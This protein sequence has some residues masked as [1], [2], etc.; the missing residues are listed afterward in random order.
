MSLFG[1]KKED[2]RAD[3]TAILQAEIYQAGVMELRDIIAPAALKVNPKSLSLGSK[4]ARTY[5]VISYPR[6]LTQGWFGPIINL[7][8]IFDVS[9]F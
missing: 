7:D 4:M 3:L 9:I 8:R 1:K 6:F 2:P 5:F